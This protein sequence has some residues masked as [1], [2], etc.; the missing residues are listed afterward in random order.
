MPA[1]PTRY[2]IIG[3]GA[4]GLAVAKRFAE[5]GIP[6]DCFERETDVG[7]I[8]NPASPHAVY[9][10]T[11]F[12]SS[13]RMSKFTDFAMPA[14]YPE[15]MSRA[16]AIEYLRAYARAFGLYD[17]IAFGSPVARAEPAEEGWRIA[18][19]GEDAP[20][21]YTGV[22]VANGHHWSPRLPA[23]QGR[24]D[25]E[26]LHSRDVKSRSQLRGKRV[27]VVGA[28]NSAADIVSDAATDGAAAF[29]SMRRCN[30]FVPKLMFGRPTDVIID[31]M[32][33]W[34]LPRRAM[35]AIY[36]A[37]L[38]VVIGPHE[39]YG[40][41]APD[42]RLFEA[43][44]TII[45]NYL[46]HIAHGRI[47]LRPEIDRLQGGAVRFKDGSTEAVDLIVCAT[48]FR[49][50]FPFMDGSLL[51]DGEG[52]PH[53]FL[54]AVHRQRDDLFAAG[55]IEPAEGGVWQLADYQAQLIASFIVA[56]A[57]DPARAD[58]FRALKATAHPDVGHGLGPGDSDWH[59]FE[60]Q[61]YR[62]R[63]YIK[64][65]LARFGPVAEAGFQDAAEAA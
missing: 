8:W 16:Q 1:T 21:T 20:R 12:N 7:G 33:R 32:S 53:L 2:C 54:Q 63:T 6:F 50:S 18:I 44:P 25:G 28:G 45:T 42:H 59:K 49:P 10:G 57:R 52:R 51:L 23:Y 48:G 34:P 41:S 55:L 24:F 58:R 35:R 9:D 46:N 47:A 19:E 13:K 56:A 3:A 40:L 65:L 39:K 36:T 37:G 60:I 27:L 64:R 29:H 31:K 5:R 14:D 30:Y 62:Y 43:H 38:N 15:Y 22:V 17:R 11:Y 26:I 4:S 61:H